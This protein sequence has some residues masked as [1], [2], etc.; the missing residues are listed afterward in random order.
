MEMFNEIHS[1]KSVR[2]RI[3]S[4]PNFPAFGLSASPY[5]VRMRENMDQKIHAY[6]HLLRSDINVKKVLV[7]LFQRLLT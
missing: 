4:R 2:S 3:F 1:V 5:S 6:G 7:D